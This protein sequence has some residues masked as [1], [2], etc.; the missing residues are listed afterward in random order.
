MASDL[1]YSSEFQK[2]S[3]GDKGLRVIAAS[4]TS[5]AGENFC[6][7]QAIESSVRRRYFN[8]F[9]V[10]EYWCCYLWKL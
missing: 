8:K 5:L 10:Y 4:A 6:A 9:V 7:I 2:L 1:Y 3:F